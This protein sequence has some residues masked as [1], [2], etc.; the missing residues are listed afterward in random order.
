MRRP[1]RRGTAQVPEGGG[2]AVVRSGEPEAAALAGDPADPLH[3]Q[4][5]VTALGVRAALDAEFRALLDAWW[6]AAQS[7]AGGEAHNSISGGTQSA[8]V[9]QA[10][11]VSGLSFHLPPDTDR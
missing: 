1:S 11:D 6:R 9:I 7:G 5:L 3:A 10:R 8:P 2:A 4:A